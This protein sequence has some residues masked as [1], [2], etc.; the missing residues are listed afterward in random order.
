MFRRKRKYARW[1]RSDE[2]FEPGRAEPSLQVVPGNSESERDKFKCLHLL[3]ETAV[4]VRQ[5][6][7]ERERE[8]AQ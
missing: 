7:R 8:A 3:V 5:R 4:A 6:E 1:P 2:L